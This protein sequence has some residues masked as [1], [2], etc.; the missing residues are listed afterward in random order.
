MPVVEEIGAIAEIVFGLEMDA[1]RSSQLEI[2]DTTEMV[3]TTEIAGIEE[4]VGIEE[5]VGIED[6]RLVTRQYSSDEL[7]QISPR[8]IRGF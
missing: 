4:I 8:Y 6:N 3:G 5:T 7:P 2:P 1:E